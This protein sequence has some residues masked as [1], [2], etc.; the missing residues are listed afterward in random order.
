[1]NKS[2]KKPGKKIFLT[3]I[4]GALLLL[5]VGLLIGLAYL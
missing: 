5:F 1:M 3:L 4:L 2:N